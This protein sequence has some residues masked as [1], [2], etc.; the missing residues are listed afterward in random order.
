MSIRLNLPN[1]LTL[2]RIGLAALLMALLAFSF[3]LAKSLALLVFVAAGITDYLDGALARGRYGVSSFG[4]LMD[5]LA[6]KVLTC[7]A[8]VSFVGMRLPTMPD[9]NLIPAWI[10]V[11]IIAREFL[12]TG[13]RLLAAARGRV[14]PAGAWGKHKM[15]WQ[16]AA[17]IA[18]L[19]GLA[20]R[21]DLMP[22]GDSD[23]LKR[24]D[25]AF[26]YIAF[27]LMLAAMT[28][29]VVSGAMY[30]RQHADLIAES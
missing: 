19:L 10:V 23:A 15:V 1:Q 2:A 5:P 12:V 13:L 14:V 3:P 6:D 29:T 27:A 8:L 18:V 22:P 30:V 28:I 24:Y 21:Y 17:I 11:V 16:I 20:V 4:K 25:I 7:A 26:H 9:R